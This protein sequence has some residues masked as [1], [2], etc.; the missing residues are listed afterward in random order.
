VKVASSE[1]PDIRSCR[2]L[3]LESG[4]GHYILYNG[5]NPSIIDFS[6]ISPLPEEVGDA[7]L[8]LIAINDRASMANKLL[9]TSRKRLMKA[10]NRAVKE[11]R[12]APNI[13]EMVINMI[14]NDGIPRETYRAH[15]WP[16]NNILDYY[17]VNR[18]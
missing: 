13:F 15:Y 12:Q 1:N 6:K 11:D 2:D 10:L 5:D 16:V 9:V 14:I 7:L 18:D 17:N 8:F 3:A 4:A